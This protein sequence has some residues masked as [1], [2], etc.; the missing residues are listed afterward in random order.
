MQRFERGDFLLEDPIVQW[1][2]QVPGPGVTVRHVLTHTTTGSFDYDPDRFSALTSVIEFYTKEPYRL[3]VAREV[4]TRL[5][6]TNSAPGHDLE[7]PNASVRELFDPTDLARYGNVV[8][9]MA[10]P[11]RVDGRGRATRSELPRR[12][13]AIDAST[14]VVT[15]VRDL[16][17]FDSALDQGILL[18]RDVIGYMRGGAQPGTPTGLGWFVQA[19]NG[20]HLVWHFG[21]AP[22]A[23]SSLIL[24][25]PSRN[26]TLI[27]LA[28]SDG[29]NQPF[30]LDRGDV[31]ASLFA[32]LFL[33]LFV[34]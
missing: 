16:A 13:M 11:Y 24:K 18:D 5:A 6:M 20:A 32:K 33:S 4:L 25:V 26:L 28:N 21:V 3:T 27:L 12:S 34:S 22:G 31:T 19:Y 9:R 17:Q 2:T 23:Y 30:A 7:Q 29:L 1:T 15:T 14:G 10:L 8:R